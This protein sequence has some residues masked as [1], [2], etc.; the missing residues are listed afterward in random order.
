MAV[1]VDNHVNSRPQSGLLEADA[2]IELL[3]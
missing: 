1:K 2:V 3:V